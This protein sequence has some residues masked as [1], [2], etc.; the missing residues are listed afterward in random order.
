MIELFDIKIWRYE[1]K[2]VVSEFLQQEIL[3]GFITGKTGIALSYRQL[4]KICTLVRSSNNQWSYH[5]EG[6]WI[7]LRREGKLFCEKKMD[8]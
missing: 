1:R 3:V 6:N 7:I 5:L 8:C 4:E 2:F